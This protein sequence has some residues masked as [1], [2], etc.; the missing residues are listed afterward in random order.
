MNLENYY[1]KGKKYSITINPIDKYQFN[2]TSKRI[3]KFKSFVYDQLVGIGP[4][5]KLYIEFSEPHGMKTQ[6][7]LGPRLHLHGTIEFKSTR[8]IGNWLC[9]DMYNIYKWASMDID[10]V[11]DEEIWYN[12]CTKQKLIKNNLITNYYDSDSNKD[13]GASAT[14]ELESNSR[15]DEL[16]D[17]IV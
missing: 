6:G 1:V 9:Y 10:V 11:N 5:Y 13:S 12:Y 16:F 14:K 15:S 3:Q 4:E 8:D 17:M 7:Y 2:A